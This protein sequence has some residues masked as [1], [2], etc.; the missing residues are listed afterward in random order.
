MTTNDQKN[1]NQNNTDPNKANLNK[2]NDPKMTNSTIVYYPNS[3]LN[4]K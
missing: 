3:S 4:Q 1:T 2:T